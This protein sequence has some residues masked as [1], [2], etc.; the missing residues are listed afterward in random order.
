MYN[1]IFSLQE[2]IFK[3]IANHKRL[4]IIQLLK[5][6]ELTVSEMIEMLGIRQANL[7]QHLSLLRLHGVVSARKVG[8]N[9]HYKLSDERIAQ[10]TQLI[11]DFLMDQRKLDPASVLGI[12]QDDSSTYPVVVDPV[13]LMR[14]SVSEAGAVINYQSRLVYFCAS[15]CETKFIVSPERYVSIFKEA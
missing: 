10:A 6:R 8:Q 5:D 1:K 9:V 12:S 13:C 2:D 3:V 4:E 15:G 11:R 14:L 7:S